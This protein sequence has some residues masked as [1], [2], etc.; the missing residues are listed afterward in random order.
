MC[1][2]FSVGLSGS[3]MR[4]TW[5][6]RDLMCRSIQ[7]AEILSL[8]PSNHLIK[9][10]GLK[11]VFFTR[12]HFFI[13]VSLSACSAQNSSG[14]SMDFRYMSSYFFLSHQLLSAKSLSTGI[15]L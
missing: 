3:Q 1:L 7:L 11:L 15:I 9:R 8:A 12:V 13:Q 4:A 10:G 5:L 14:D 6:A 2:G